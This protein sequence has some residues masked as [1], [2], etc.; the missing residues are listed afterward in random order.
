MPKQRPDKK[1]PSRY[2]KLALCRVNATL[3]EVHGLKISHLGSLWP[4][5][6]NEPSFVVVH[7][8]H[9]EK[10][11]LI[12]TQTLEPSPVRPDDDQ[13]EPHD[14]STTVMSVMSFSPSSPMFG[15]QFIT[16]CVLPDEELMVLSTA[17]HGTAYLTFMSACPDWAVSIV[18]TQGLKVEQLRARTV[19]P[20]QTLVA[21]YDNQA[22]LVLWTFDHRTPSGLSPVRGFRQEHGGSQSTATKVV[23]RCFDLGRHDQKTCVLVAF[24]ECPSCRLLT[25]GGQLLTYLVPD[26]GPV[27]KLDTALLRR[28]FKQLVVCDGTGSVLGL[29]GDTATAFEFKV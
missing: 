27:L 5:T 10:L 7:E 23:P 8:L 19:S 18:E 2:P 25:G 26:D 17:H 22:G 6:Q 1:K 16:G 28:K 29:D 4:R 24:C 20:D 12:N 13:D 21:A 9:S 3:R 14:V 11:F 15:H